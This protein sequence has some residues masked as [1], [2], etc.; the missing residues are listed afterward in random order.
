MIDV[1]GF[2]ETDALDTKAKTA[3]AKTLL[4]RPFRINGSNGIGFTAKNDRNVVG[5]RGKTSHPSRHMI[6]GTGPEAERT[7]PVRQK[8]LTAAQRILDNA[9]YIEKHPDTNHDSDIRYVDLY[10]A[11][12]DGAD[13]YP[14]HIIAREKGDNP[15]LFEVKKAMYYDLKKE[16]PLPTRTSPG[17][18]MAMGNKGFS[19]ISVAELLQN[20][21]DKAGRPY[22]TNGQLNYDS[23][24]L[25]TLSAPELQAR[26]SGAQYSISSAIDTGFKKAEQYVN[27]NVRAANTNTAE[28]R[29][30]QI[31]ANTGTKTK[32]QSIIGYLKEF[33]DKF[34]REWVDKNHALHYVDDFI[35]KTGGKKLSMGEKIYYRA[36]VM[37]ALANGAAT[38]LIEG[39]EHSMNA[40]R[41]RIGKDVDPK[42]KAAVA[43]AKE[44]RAKFKN[45]TMRDVLETIPNKEMD[46]KYP[47][48]LKKHGINSWREAFSN[49]IGARRLLELLRLVEDKSL[50]HITHSQKEF[51]DFIDKH[52]QYAKFRP[53]AFSG[54][55]REQVQAMARKDP[56]LAAQMAKELAKE[57]KL[58]KGISRADL[59]A[60]VNNA[61]TEFNDAAQKFYQLQENLLI[62]MED[63]HLISRAVHDKINS[64][65]KEY[66]PLVID[67]SDTA[68]LDAQLEGFISRDGTGITNVGSMLKHVLAL[69]SEHGLKSPLEST[70]NSI[71][72]LT[73]R[74]ERNKVGVHFVRMVENNPALAKSGLLERLPKKS[75]DAKNCEFAVMENGEKV[76]YKTTPDMYGPIVGYD[77]DSAGIAFNVAANTANV[78]RAGATMSPSFIF[79]NLIRDTIFAA[80]SSRNGFVPLIDSY[81]GMMAYLHDKELRGEFD[82]MGVTSYNFFGS[83]D[84][85]VKSMDELMH[86]AKVDGPISFLKWLAGNFQEASEVVEASTRMGEY[87]KARKNG[88][89]M[90][91]AA[92]DAR[93]VTLDFSRS[94]VTGQK[95]NRI[96]PFF[97]AAIQGGD[98]M[99]RLIAD[100][101]TR[102]QTLR[103]LATRIILP[104]LFLWAL[105]HDEPWYEELDPDIKNSYWILP[106]GK[107][108]IPKPQEAGVV[109]GSG[110][111]AIM[112]QLAKKDPVAM[113][114]WAKAFRDVALPNMIP[115]IGLP[116]LEWWTNYS[117]FREKPI[118]GNRLKRLPVEQRYNSGT[119]ELS[120]F[121][122]DKAGLSPVKLDNT[123]RGYLGTMGMFAWQ[124]PDSLFEGKRNLPSKKFTARTFVRDLFINDMNMNRTQ[125]DFYDLVEKAQQQHA[126]YGKKGKPTAE[127]KAINKAMRDVSKVN[128][129]I[130]EIMNSKTMN[131]DQKRQLIDNKRKVLH[132]I[133]KATI[134]RY[135]S[136]FE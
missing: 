124:L 51:T 103:M 88:K 11:V 54:K 47:D 25:P 121:I 42:N 59:E 87:M 85:M 134:N 60:T 22:V 30:S 4:N 29:T 45:V 34:Y 28:G 111:E 69:G 82:A 105:N 110:A 44:L 17:R 65:Y 86:E 90:E 20:V 62:L 57:Y 128:K 6:G 70:Y 77:E 1:T 32:S 136:K 116:L 76:V 41:E 133:Q 63:G 49:Y 123:A 130:Q 71:Q 10:A 91:E 131:S 100:E 122:G 52:P 115:T 46:S 61:P 64:M 93:D 126:G 112:D 75:A 27:R 31:Y 53:K 14:I 94:G 107:I 73:N 67:Y 80:V 99:I 135:G 50:Q 3:L 98:K 129:D 117:L 101:D 120:K 36:Q 8:A 72:M 33:K 55:W 56:A 127:V 26:S 37:R 12:Q 95:Y 58:P 132:T 2:A 118:E 96:V 102:A 97:N 81:K 106:G 38:T 16:N 9:I 92:L 48:Y 84:N 7:D 89:S 39:N 66:C 23:A 109:F 79:R 18:G 24:A 78:L 108:R 74:A 114:N 35:E 125:E 13:V 21:K 43:R 5:G 83:T 113:K 119:S 68:P 104:S 15:G 19:E 40:L